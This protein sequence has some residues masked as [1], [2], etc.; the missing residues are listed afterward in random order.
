M[1]GLLM[2]KNKVVWENKWMKVKQTPSGFTF[3]ERL[4]KDS[5][6]F[7]LYDVDKNLVGLVSEYK[8]PID[9]FVLTAFGGSIDKEEYRSK[10]GIINLVKDEVIEESGFTVS[11]N[12]IKYVGKALVSTQMNQFC[13]LFIVLINKD[14]QGER[15]TTNP[16]ERLA[17]IHWVKPSILFST[18][19]K[20]W[21]AP[22]IYGRYRFKN[23]M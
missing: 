23:G 22:T 16:T 6:A 5:I 10:T 20:D 12:D 11:E 7:I 3:A 8:D 2:E 13:L 1:K 4:G 19:L 14:K 17:E 15:T 18:S 21:K 9:K